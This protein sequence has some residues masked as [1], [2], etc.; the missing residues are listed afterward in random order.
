MELAF[1]GFRIHDLKRTGTNITTSTGTVIP[2]TSNILVLP[3]P[4]R[5]T[6]LNDPANPVLI[7]NPGY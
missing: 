6:D 2:I 5:E 3:I 1:E 7:Q 4:K